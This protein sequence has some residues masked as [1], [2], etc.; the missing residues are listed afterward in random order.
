M[1]TRNVM[2]ARIKEKSLKNIVLLKKL[3]S[4]L[5]TEA[6]G[7]CVML[8]NIYQ[9]IRSHILEISDLNHLRKEVIFPREQSLPVRKRTQIP[10]SS[11][12]YP[13][14]YTDRAIL[15]LMSLVIQ[16]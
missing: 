5:K 7:S 16:L 11:T 12:T 9:T 2:D 14:H 3:S 15:V 10:W 6:A 8:L 13:S 4:S 1:N